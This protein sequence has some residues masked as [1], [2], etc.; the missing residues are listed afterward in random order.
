MAEARPQTSVPDP[1]E[2][3][4]RQREVGT[5]YRAL[6]RWSEA[7]QR[8]LVPRFRAAMTSDQAAQ[9]RKQELWNKDTN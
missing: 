1:T 7:Q 8:V 3:L 5:L 4:E 9:F 6:S 2:N